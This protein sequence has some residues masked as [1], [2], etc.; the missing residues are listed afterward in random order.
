MTQPVLSTRAFAQP[1]FRAYPFPLGVASGEPWPDSVVLWTR[2]A[3]EPLAGGG[4]PMV[5]V[6]VGWEV[7]QRSGLHFDGD[8]RDGR[9][10]A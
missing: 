9:G 5:N 1:L 8:E 10:A 4:M 6:E 3:P 7:A 2:L